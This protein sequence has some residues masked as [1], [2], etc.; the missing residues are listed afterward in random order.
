[1]PKSNEPISIDFREPK[2]K[3]QLLLFL[4]INESILNII[5]KK[6]NNDS[7][8]K[9]DNPLII[10]GVEIPFL[11]LNNFIQHKIPKKGKPGKYRIVWEASGLISDAYKTFTRR[12]DLFLRFAEK[13]YPH[14]CAYGYIRGRS[15][16][17]N[18]SPHCGKRFLL[19]ADIHNF[20]PSIS[21]ERIYNKFISLEIKPEVAKILTHIVTIDNS[22]PLG[23][24]SSPMLANLV[25]MELDKQF[26]DLAL[27]YNCSYTRYADDISISG[28]VD[29]PSKE[30]INYI[31]KK[32]GFAISESKFRITKPGQAHYV[33]GLSITDPKFP[34]APRSMKRKLRQ[35]LYYCKKY[36]IADHLERIDGAFDFIKRGVNRIDGTV[37]YIGNIE[38]IALPNLRENWLSLLKKDDLE[39]SYTSI[40]RDIRYIVFYIDESVVE[41]KG[42]TYL[43]LSLAL[44]ENCNE[45]DASTARILHDHLI[46]PYSGGKKKILEKKKMH[47]SDANEDLR[48]KYIE[49]L[50]SAP[51]RGYLAFCKLKSNKEYKNA[52]VS[53]LKHTLRNRFMGCD[54]A[55]VVM[56]FE[57]N[58][59][60]P[61]KNIKDIVAEVYTDLKKT[62]NRRP[63]S[64][65]DVIIGSK[66]G[67]LNFAIPDFLLGVWG[68]YIKKY[69]GNGDQSKFRFERLRDKYRII[70]DIDNNI[71][72]SRKRPFLPSALV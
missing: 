8:V 16:I 5:V 39:P 33:T 21:F 55:V 53:L 13:G 23:L 68:D 61:I 10:Q 63:V 17:E 47:Y 20:F 14:S 45:I 64:P 59:K 41:Y 32:Q 36:G 11:R 18:A 31:L 30:E 38:E 49:Y 72:F 56:I 3:D 9:K 51:F 43:A 4:G 71:T 50:V 69:D 27:K 34:R 1:M 29:V 24:H 48:K 65:P 2:N 15:T 22:L 57:E 70:F 12:F 66:V 35:E 52:Y 60:V 40:N 37:R 67:H 44:T 6:T 62:D 46:D 25:C 7:S 19:K 42:E 58:S 54:S 28:N 26:Y